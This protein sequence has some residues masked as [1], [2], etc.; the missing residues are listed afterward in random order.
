MNEMANINHAPH[1]FADYRIAWSISKRLYFINTSS[2]YEVNGNCKIKCYLFLREQLMY[3]LI[4]T[5]NPEINN[6][7]I[8]YQ[9]LIKIGLL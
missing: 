2:S 9:S 4:G 5:Q 8:Y 7:E 1:V 6:P 3:I